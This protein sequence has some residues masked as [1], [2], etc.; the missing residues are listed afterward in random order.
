MW[1]P[2]GQNASS[3][4]ARNCRC[5]R[6]YTTVLLV[7][8]CMRRLRPVQSA[9]R[10]SEKASEREDQASA[11]S[12]SP[13]WLLLVS[14]L[15]CSVDRSLS[16]RLAVPVQS[17]SPRDKRDTGKQAV[18]DL[19]TRLTTGR[20]PI[21]WDKRAKTVSGRLGTGSH[22]PSAIVHEQLPG[23][24]VV[25]VGVPLVVQVSAACGTQSTLHHEP[26]LRGHH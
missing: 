8:A 18:P 10:P 1:R 6:S 9:S 15:V 26:A 11:P 19:C 14:A 17:P 4:A 21:P 7:E 23:L 16:L 22:H 25:R 3:R 2:S 5:V 20:A 24:V 12:L 13:L